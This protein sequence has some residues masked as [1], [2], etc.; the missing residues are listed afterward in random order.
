[1]KKIFLSSTY[2][3]LKDFRKAAIEVLDRDY[4]A[5]A[6]EKFFAENHQAKDVCLRKVQE[7]DAL[8]L[9]LG[10]RYGT[11][12]PI[13]HV[14][15]TEVEYTTAK[16]LG[17]PVFAFV[18]TEDDGNWR[19]TEHDSERKLKHEAFKKR[20]DQDKHRKDFQTYDQLK[21]EILGAITNYERS[22][23]E[24]GA[25][26]PSLVKRDQFFKPF[27]N[28]ERLFNHTWDLVGRGDTLDRL[29]RFVDSTKQVAIIF[30]PGTIGKTKVLFEFSNSFELKHFGKQLL[31]LREGLAITEESIRQIPAQPTVLVVDDAHRR[32]DL[33]ILFQLGQ[34][35]HERIKLILSSRPQGKDSVKTALSE[36]GYGFQAIEDLELEQLNRAQLREL[37]SQVLGTNKERL[38][39]SLVSATRDSPLVTLVGAQLLLNQSIDPNMLER[40]EAFQYEVLSRFEDAVTGNISPSVNQADV[41]KILAL[42]SALAPIRPGDAQFQQLASEFLRIEKRILIDIIGALEER[43]V[44]TRRGYTVRIAPD[45][46]SD[47][48]LH[49]ACVTASGL[50]TG[51]ADEIFSR[52]AT[53]AGERVLLNLAE[54]DWRIAKTGSQALLLNRIWRDLER[55]FRKGS[56]SERCMI[57]DSLG[58]VAYYQPAQA[59]SLVDLSL[60]QP[61][62]NSR[63]KKALH[64]YNFTNA[65][66]IRRL[67]KVIQAIGYNVDYLPRC[68]DLLW[69]LGRNDHRQLNSNLESPMRILS[70]FAAYDI[71]KPFYVNRIVLDAVERW[72]KQPDAHSHVH[73]PM[74][75][76]DVLL[77]KEGLSSRS[78]GPNVILQ[79]FAIPGENTKALRVRAIELL[80]ISVYSTAPRVMMRSLHSLTNVLRP[81]HASLGRPI[82]TGEKRHW[83]SEQKAILTII[84]RLARSTENT[85]AHVRITKDLRWHARHANAQVVKENSRTIIGSIP[86][87]FEYLLTKSLWYNSWD[88]YD[89]WEGSDACDYQKRTQKTEAKIGEIAKSFLTNFAFPSHGFSTLNNTLEHL[90]QAGITPNPGYFFSVLSRT[91]PRY[92]ANISRLIVRK[93]KSNLSPYLALLL[94]GP[95]T[96]NKSMTMQV[97]RQALKSNHEPLL[98]AVAIFFSWGDELEAGDLNYVKKLLN[99]KSLVVKKSAIYALKNFDARSHVAVIDIVKKLRLTRNVELVDAVCGLFSEKPERHAIA[100]SILRQADVSAILEKLLYIPELHDHHHH[101]DRFLGYASEKNPF[102]VAKLFFNRLDHKKKK[103][104]LRNGYHPLPFLGFRYAFKNASSKPG[105][106]PIINELLRRASRADGMD[107]FWLPIFF[108]GISDGYCQACLDNLKPWIRSRNR[109]KIEAAALLLRSAPADFLFRQKNFVIEL[110]ESAE[111]LSEDC[112]RNVRSSLFACA[113]SGLREGTPGLPKAHDVNIRDKSKDALS[114]LQPGAAA[115]RF[116]D[117]LVQYAE[118]EIRDDRARFEEDFGD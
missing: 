63:N 5:V 26:V 94:T 116:Y 18:K 103:R 68:C 80:R 117:S 12:D 64:I 31:F 44:L 6:M 108:A 52:F 42:I 9:L 3:D 115:Y 99:H 28:T 107:S 7:C 72:L 50:T 93:P 1:M 109:R 65:D 45:V 53:I 87:T 83:L 82:T 92:A 2:I 79:S 84:S 11:V 8:V 13:E 112:Y 86:E 66:V 105:Y 33:K 77:K 25:R 81:P 62:K 110:L 97:I 47:H 23:G 88:W 48:I 67:P 60:R 113:V 24:L 36:T 51:F 98:S 118:G 76:L 57:L 20:I 71:G 14:S 91:D 35:Y 16:A 37:G 21:I 89:D 19:S 41:R 22:H 40:H 100:F 29:H 114:Q 104:R 61:A 75:I 74:D 17:L 32:S 15:I 55:A 95:R 4:H 56:N 46:L 54:L 34:Q 38:V 30:G 49:K 39:N 10:D 58:K 59:L 102:L 43:G 106:R 111:L 90:N 27:L 78:E 101:I 85:I 69:R 70:D 96:D 73:S